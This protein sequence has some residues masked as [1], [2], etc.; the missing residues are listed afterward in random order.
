MD[1]HLFQSILSLKHLTYHEELASKLCF[2]QHYQRL[3]RKVLLE[4]C[5]G[6]MVVPH[7]KAYTLCLVDQV[8]ELVNFC[9]IL[10]HEIQC[11]CTAALFE[12]VE[13][14]RNNV[15]YGPKHVCGIVC[16]NLSHKSRTN[17]VYELLQFCR[18]RGILHNQIGLAMLLTQLQQM[19]GCLTTSKATFAFVE[20]CC[21]L[22]IELFPFCYMVCLVH[23]LLLQTAGSQYV[24]H[25]PT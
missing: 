11:V 13:V 16:A 21:P 12:N 22:L 1:D 25:C 23:V 8:L 18:R 17:C 24:R 4:E 14:R 6:H 10:Q 20:K 9:P 5:H 3:F 19:M 15:I 2:Y 7:V